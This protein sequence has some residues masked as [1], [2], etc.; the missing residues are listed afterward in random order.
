MDKTNGICVK[1][2]QGVSFHR[3]LPDQ[4]LAFIPM[5]TVRWTIF[6]SLLHCGNIAL[7]HIKNLYETG[8]I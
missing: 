5:N 2:K 1:D 3:C 6:D 4:K 7:R 8:L